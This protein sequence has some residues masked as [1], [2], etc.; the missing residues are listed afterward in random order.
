MRLGHFRRYSK[1]ELCRKAKQVGFYIKEIYFWNML[2]ILPYWFFEKLLKREL[3]DKLRTNP[4]RTSW[5]KRLLIS[6]L[7]NW[8]IL[9]SKFPPPVGLSLIAVLVKNPAY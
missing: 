8:L 6:C 7:S 1:A 4:N 3:Y 5:G 9:E 2:G